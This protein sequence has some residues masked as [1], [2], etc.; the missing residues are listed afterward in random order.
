[1]SQVF[2]IEQT[3]HKPAAAESKKQSELSKTAT[4]M[5]G[6]IYYS[7]PFYVMTSA[8]AICTYI[9]ICLFSIIGFMV[10]THYVLPWVGS[11]LQI[12]IQTQHSQRLIGGCMNLLNEK[13]APADGGFN[14]V[15]C[16]ELI[17]ALFASRLVGMDGPAA[18]D[19]G[20]VSSPAVEMVSSMFSNFTSHDL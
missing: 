3:Q 12:L 16:L 2:T 17:N 8:E 13:I 6:L 11:F 15:A 5:F 7:L 18:S 4:R 1:M 14:I 9:T 19:S 10:T 20:L